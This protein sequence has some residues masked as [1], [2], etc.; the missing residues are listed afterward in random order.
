MLHAMKGIAP[1]KDT[2]SIFLPR[3]AMLAWFMLSSCVHLS[4]R[5]SVRPKSEFYKDG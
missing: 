2:H 1:H 5:P 3:D 4:V